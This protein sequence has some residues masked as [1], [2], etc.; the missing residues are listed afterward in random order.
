MLKRTRLS[1]AISAAFGAGL[2]GITPVVLAQ[3]TQQLDRVEITG[4]SLRRADAETALPVTIIRADELVKQ[5]ITTVEQ[6]SRHCRKTRQPRH[7]PSHWQDQRRRCF[8]RLARIGRSTGSTGQRTLVLLNGS[9]LA[10]QAFDSGAV[11]LSA[12]PLS[13]VDRIEVLRDGASAIYGT[14]A[15]GGVVNFILRRDYTGVE[16]ALEYQDPQEEGG[17]KTR[18]YSLT[19][20]FGSLDNRAL[21]LRDYRLA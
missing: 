8:R 11:D 2:V 12:I 18:R 19:G 15:I 4:S 10:N 3:Q 21:T 16:A 9:R 14:D 17:G 7:Q 13:A 6:A 5:G 1:L 20:G